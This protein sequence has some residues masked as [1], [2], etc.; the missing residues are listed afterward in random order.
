MMS[1]PDK[2]RPLIGRLREW[3]GD[4]RYSVRRKASLPFRATSDS[5]GGMGWS[6]VGRT[7]DVSTTG[8][9]MLFPAPEPGGEQRALSGSTFFLTLQIGRRQVR[10]VA[11]PT[12]LAPAPAEG[13]ERSGVRLVGARIDMVEEQDR[14]LLE[15]YVR[16][17]R[18]PARDVA[19]L[20]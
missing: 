4:R 12:R 6:V 16:S 17:R 1:L 14:V 8:L 18:F 19:P 15:N 11:T 13:G 10:L 2:L 20:L 9:G 5:A 3:V 7:H